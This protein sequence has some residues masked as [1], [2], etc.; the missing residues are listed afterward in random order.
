MLSASKFV[1]VCCFPGGEFS[2]L[3]CYKVLIL[4]V[5]SSWCFC[6]CFWELMFVLSLSKL[7]LTVLSAH[8]SSGKTSLASYKKK[9]PWV[10]KATKE[11]PGTDRMMKNSSGWLYE[12]HNKAMNE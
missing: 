8:H 1:I 3:M 11:N 6:P 7:T 9:N 12:A 2:L 10:P 4:W 5:G